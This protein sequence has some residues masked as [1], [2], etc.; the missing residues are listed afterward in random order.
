[1]LRGIAPG[2]WLALA[3]IRL[4][5]LRFRQGR[6]VPALASYQEGF[7]LS[8]T[9]DFWIGLVNG[10]SNMTELMLTNGEA[11]R[12]IRQLKDLRDEQPPSRRTPLMS[13]LACHLLA[14][15]DAAGMREAAREAINQG[16]AIGLTAAV[17]WAVE[18]VALLAATQ[19]NVETAAR[20]AGYTRIVHPSLA[21]RTGAHKVVADR[22]Y[23]RLQAELPP[24]SLALALAEG[25][26]WPLGTAADQARRVLGPAPN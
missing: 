2:K 24:E 18:A 1:M 7:A 9:T 17:A 23:E 13:T 25:G 5:D 26:R 10:G 6:H 3:L 16:S 11:E 4:G 14:A 8:R 12:A 21:T 19:G 15:G 22:L 20:L